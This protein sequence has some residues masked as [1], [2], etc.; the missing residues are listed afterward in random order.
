VST[1]SKQPATAERHGRA[2]LERLARVGYAARGVIYIIVGV[3]AFLAAIGSGG[4]ATG[5]K[6]AITTL[7]EAPAGWLLVL[8]ISLGL[9]GYSIWRFCQGFFDADNHGRGG[10]ALAIRGGLISSSVTHLLLAVWAGELALGASTSSGSD[11]GNESIVASLMSQPFGQWLVGLFGV[12]LIGVGFAQFAKG[13]D[14]TFEKH[15]TWNQETRRKLAGFCRFGL[16]ARGVIF[17]IVGTF[18]IFAAVNMDP[19]DAGGLQEALAW[20]GSQPFGP[21]LLGLVAAG[22]VCFGIYSGVEAVYRR[23]SPPT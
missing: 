5:T 16:Y 21:W 23:V 22:L 19:S 4:R 6:G 13:H 20:L 17:V 18:I 3:L 12:I 8:A 2:W 1:V 10:K 9:F 14:E 11:G 7:L 15:F